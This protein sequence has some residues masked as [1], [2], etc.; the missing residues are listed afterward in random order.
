MFVAMAAG[1]CYPNAVED[2]KCAFFCPKI[3]DP[4]YDSDGN[5]YSE[6]KLYNLC[7]YKPILAPGE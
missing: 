1:S 3:F 5:M 4:I 2:D 6:S 7:Y